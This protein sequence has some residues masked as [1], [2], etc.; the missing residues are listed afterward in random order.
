MALKTNYQDAV[1]TQKKLRLTNNGDGTVTPQDA[2]IY[3]QEGDQFGAK[4]INA[5][6]EAV[7]RLNHTTEVTLTTAGWT[8]SAPPYTQTAAAPG[9]TEEMDALLVSAL[10]DGASAAAQ[11]AYNKAFG[12]ISS[13]T[14]VIGNGAATFKV[15]K[16][17]ATDCKVGLKGV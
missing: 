7:N 17:P 5:V 1:F 12:I 13:G 15:Y 9:A 11:L 4:D 16:K 8:G 14:A 3:T 2:T 10:S 6:N